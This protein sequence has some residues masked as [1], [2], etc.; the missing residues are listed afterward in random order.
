M[1]G[2][3]GGGAAATGD[4]R[5]VAPPA[6]G[7][8][9][10]SAEAGGPAG[11]AAAGGVGEGAGRPDLTAFLER[12]GFDRSSALYKAAVRIQAQYRGYAVRKARPA[13]C[14]VLLL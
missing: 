10:G 8:A 13:Y 4:P 11:A 14:R 9:A 12:G 3:A 2:D 6:A 5:G 1:G 7:A